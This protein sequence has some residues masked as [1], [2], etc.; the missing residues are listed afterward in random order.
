[1][2]RSRFGTM[3]RRAA[4]LAGG[5]MAATAATAGAD[6]GAGAGAGAQDYVPTFHPDRLKGPPP[7]PANQ[8]LVL[9]SPHLSAYK[10]LPRAAV[11]PLLDKLAAWRPEVIATEDLS[12]RLCDAMR[13]HPERYAESIDTYCPDPTAAGAALGLDVPAA[14]I[15]AERMLAD[16]PAVPTAAQR[17]RLAALFLAAGE[18]NSAVV[19]WLRLPEGERHAGDGLDAAMAAE[20]G[21]RWAR[22]G[23]S[24]WVAAALAARLGL[25]RLYSVDDHSAD[26]A[27]PPALEKAFGEAIARAWDNP[28]GRERKAF[29]TPFED[30]IAAPGGIL[31]IYRAYNSPRAQELAFRSDFGAALMEPSAQ[32]FGRQYVGYWETRNLRMVANIRDVLGLN[33]GKRLLAIVGASHKGYYEAYLNQMH[34]VRLVDAEKVLR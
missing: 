13:R 14:N 16:W 20:I 30:A 18:P 32:R 22:P 5:L 6:T 4:M 3:R 33:P 26:A 8:V 19:Q 11:T 2:M 15:A 34:D 28:A 9:G 25:E 7:G 29:M 31:A 21:R 1:M 23:E 27:N 24:E 10:T 17:R 12:G